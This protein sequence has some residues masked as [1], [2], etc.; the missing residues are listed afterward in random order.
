MLSPPQQPRNAS[1]L[2]SLFQASTSSS[3]IVTHPQSTTDSS[4]SS[5]AGTSAAPIIT[6]PSFLIHPSIA[7]DLTRNMCRNQGSKLKNFPEGKDT[8]EGAWNNGGGD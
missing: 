4:I 7:M 5:I 3:T 2:S 8:E 1:P 6:H